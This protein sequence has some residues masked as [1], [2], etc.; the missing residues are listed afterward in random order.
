MKRLALFVLLCAALAGCGAL[1]D[2]LS[3][4]TRV[5]DAGYTS[6]S[7]YHRSHNGTDTLEI[8][9]SAEDQAHDYEQ[10]AKIVWDTYPEHLDQL[11]IKLNGT[12]Q[13]YAEATL[14]DT[15]GERQVT[16]KPDDDAAA[17]KSAV[18]WMIVGLVVFLLLGIGATILV[19]V[20]VRRSRSRN[21]RYPPPPTWPPAGPPAAQDS[22]DDAK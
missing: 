7:V 14:R 10:I 13:T 5:Q 2:V 12:R 6:V 8:T 18:T 22:T 9:A 15:F 20:L 3:L 16:E 4:R 1:D 19:V 11:S 21:P 17:M